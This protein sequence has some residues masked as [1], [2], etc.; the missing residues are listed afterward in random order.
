MNLLMYFIEEK[1]EQ[2]FVIE[3]NRLVDSLGLKYI[4]GGSQVIPNWVELQAQTI[5]R[6]PISNNW[7]AQLK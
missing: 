6:D 4:S 1:N 5:L 3:L 7:F 2:K